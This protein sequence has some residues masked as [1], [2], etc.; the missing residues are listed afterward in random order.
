M[1]RREFGKRLGTAVLGTTFPTSILFENK[2]ADNTT[3]SS[4]TKVKLPKEVAG[5]P[6]IDSKVAQEATDLARESSPPFLLNH[7]M[8]TYLFGARLGKDLAFD[9]VLLFLSWIRHDLCLTHRN[10]VEKPFS[11]EGAR[12]AR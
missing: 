9:H 2:E 4:Q 11:T 1:N 10:A 7:S 6:L 5:I 12:A 8:R 3:I